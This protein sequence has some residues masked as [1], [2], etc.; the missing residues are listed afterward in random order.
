MSNLPGTPRSNASTPPN[1]HTPPTIGL[2]RDPPNPIEKVDQVASKAFMQLVSPTPNLFSQ[3]LDLNSAL[4]FPT[5]TEQQKKALD[6]FLTQVKTSFVN[7]S[8]LQNLELRT[9]LHRATEKNR[10]DIVLNFLSCLTLDQKR[11]SSGVAIRDPLKNLNLHKELMEAAIAAGH[12]VLLHEFIDDLVGKILCFGP[13]DAIKFYESIVDF[14]KK[15]IFLEPDNRKTLQN[16]LLK[17]LEQTFV[18]RDPLKSLDIRKLLISKAFFSNNS[19]LLEY[20]IHDSVAKIHFEIDPDLKNFLHLDLLG[21]LED[22]PQSDKQIA[23]LK[24][25][26]KIYK[27]LTPPQ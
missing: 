2:G 5:S 19:E 7:A 6:D 22:L 23:L 25:F 9:F 12:Q 26:K 17:Y 8:T 21:F 14:I 27:D 20:L 15:T 24:I 1:H 10:A 16:N 3:K 13:Q 11:D 18:N 4:N